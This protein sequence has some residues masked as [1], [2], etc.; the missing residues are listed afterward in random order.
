M[1]TIR[2][3]APRGAKDTPIVSGTEVEALL[4]GFLNVPPA[5]SPQSIR[6]RM[7]YWRDVANNPQAHLKDG[8]FG[9]AAISARRKVAIQSLRKLI[10]RNPAIAAQLQ[11][12]A[13]SQEAE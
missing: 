6:E 9:P 2:S 4:K 10:E 13:N 1:T 3:T 5:R 7:S 12:E 11:R 8:E